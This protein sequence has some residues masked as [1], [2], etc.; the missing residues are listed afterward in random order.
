MKE[1]LAEIVANTWEKTLSAIKV[2]LEAALKDCSEMLALEDHY[3]HGNQDESRL[4]SSLGGFGGGLFDV[5]SM[6]N[7]LSQGDEKR[8][9]S[10][11]RYERMQRMSE[12]LSTEL[13]ELEQRKPS[14]FLRPA[15]KTAGENIAAYEEEVNTF[16][17]LFALIRA[18]KL[19]SAAKYEER[20][21][22][23]FAE[24]D[25]RNLDDEEA[26]LC[27]PYVIFLDTAETDEEGEKTEMILSLL[28]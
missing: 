4:Q 19:E 12:S 15:L 9:M 18:A 21:D 11:E 6:S 10:N 26:A 13:A 28:S 25:W 27:P 16:A 23:F 5:S 20:H 14:E 24:F 7:L 17:K 8:R 3:R 22:A 1:A 2:Q